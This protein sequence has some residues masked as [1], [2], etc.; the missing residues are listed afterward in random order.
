MKR[1]VFILIAVCLV[2]FAACS[3]QPG[4]VKTDG[5]DIDV[6]WEDSDAPYYEGKLI[7]GYN[8]RS[9]VDEIVNL[10]NARVI[11]EI[12][13]LNA[14]SI[15]FNCSVKEARSKIKDFLTQNPVL[16]NQIRY[17]E[18][19]Y[20]RNLIEPV[21]ASEQE[22]SEILSVDVTKPLSKKNAVIPDLMEYVWGVKKVKAPEAWSLGYDG[23]G[24]LVAVLD[25]G[26]DATHPDL[27][28]Q[29]V[30]RYDPVLD[31]E[32]ATDI[33]YSFEAHATHVAG[34]IAAKA[35][36][37]GVTGVAPGARLIDIPIFQP[38]YIGDSYVALGIIWAV[39]NGAK[40]LSN[41]WGG[42]GY[43]TLLHDAINYALENGAVFVA[44]AGNDHTDEV[45][46][47]SC[48]PGVINVAA[49]T[50][51]DG[52]TD[53]STRGEWVTVAAPGDYTVLS[54]VPLWD[55]GEFTFEQP[56]AF[57]GGTSMACPHV[58][59]AVAVLLQSLL[60]TKVGVTSY[61]G[62]QIKSWLIQSADDIMASGFDK[63]SGWGRINIENALGIDPATLPEGGN[64]EFTVL[65]DRYILGDHY[66]LSGVYITLV[67]NGH[68]GPTYYGKTVSDGTVKFSDIES[69]SYDAYIGFGDYWDMSS[70]RW[71]LRTE[72]AFGIQD[73]INVSSD[74][75]KTCYLSNTPRVVITDFS[76]DPSG[77]FQIRGT[78][79][80]SGYQKTKAFATASP[81]IFYLVGSDDPGG[82]YSFEIAFTSAQLTEIT[83]NG[84]IEYNDED[85][86]QI[87]FSVDIPAGSTDWVD[88]GVPY[89][90]AL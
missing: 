9:A 53:F 89:I 38:N 65:S 20:E 8:D 35:D 41:S 52:I 85:Y 23:S 64:V 76:S 77:G 2:L 87:P 58:S 5:E 69:G 3:F 45:H 44:S 51:V 25:T 7:V 29:I 4:G 32:V 24:I 17:I 40:V 66:P 18:P 88:V 72:D 42:K 39:D 75:S 62:F 54:S 78:E 33:D 68:D 83:V 30:K 16:S 73:S 43:S 22:L 48:Y 50:A 46:Y 90:P 57:Y 6:L 67:P 80:L 11:V 60:G 10:L 71:T 36:G 86:R 79:Y 37:Q 63:D 12:E 26:I 82:L 61:T 47:P 81:G 1:T 59:G 31:T 55:T 28:G 13:K 27:Q 84:Y 74:V 70:L 49:S 34:T 19:S 21:K 56:Y 14:V 15:E